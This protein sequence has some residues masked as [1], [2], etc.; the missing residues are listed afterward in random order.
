MGYADNMTITNYSR[1]VATLSQSDLL[2]NEGELHL[3]QAELDLA[4]EE[5]APLIR[6]L[7][8][9]ELHRAAQLRFARDGRRFMAGR[10]LLRNVIASYLRCPAQEIN[11]VYGA[12]G[13][14][15][16]ATADLQFNLAHS[17]GL[18]IIGLTRSGPLGVDVERV[19]PLQDLTRLVNG[20]FSPR[21][22]LEMTALP[23]EDQQMAFFTCWTRKEA[24]LKATGDGLATPLNQFD[25]PVV[26]SAPP[27]LL[28]VDVA[29]GE[30]ESWSLWDVPLDDG[31]VGTVAFAGQMEILRH[32]VWRGDDPALA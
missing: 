19:R 24:Y 4:D 29:S 7:S 20:F 15:A 14:P 3:W 27:R 11:L 21:E 16:L 30:T 1:A 8:P 22:R 18:A 10:G 28:Q 12:R 13:K 31:F 5:L 2:L 9:D 32:G 25:M 26:P 23:P 6:V 17:D